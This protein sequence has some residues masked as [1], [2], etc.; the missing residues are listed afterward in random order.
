MKTVLYTIIKNTH[1]IH[2]YTCLMHNACDSGCYS[3]KTRHTTLSYRC[4]QPYSQH[5]ILKFQLFN[6]TPSH[7]SHRQVRCLRQLSPHGQ[8]CSKTM[9]LPQSLPLK[10]VEC[11]LRAQPDFV[12]NHVKARSISDWCAL[13]WLATE[14]GWA[15]S[16]KLIMCLHNLI[17]LEQEVRHLEY[18]CIGLWLSPEA[19]IHLS[20]HSLITT[21]K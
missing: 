4:W 10:M 18:I 2:N 8:H 13:K 19:H 6:K 15:W 11:L 12:A 14:T 21:S 9:K 20:H 17:R 1:K 16:G 7:A 5:L 3:I